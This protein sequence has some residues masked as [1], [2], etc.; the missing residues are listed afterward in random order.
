MWMRLTADFD[1]RVGQSI[2]AYVSGRTYNAP[3][4]AVVAAV[5]AG[6]AVRLKPPRK[7]EVPDA[8]A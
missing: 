5:A 4:A 3:S 2:V 8:E 7:G 6:K 1:Y